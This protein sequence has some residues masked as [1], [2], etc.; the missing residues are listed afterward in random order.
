MFCFTCFVENLTFGLEMHQIGAIFNNNKMARNLLGER[1]RNIYEDHENDTTYTCSTYR[2]H[3]INNQAFI[4]MAHSCCYQLSL[5]CIVI[6]AKFIY[7]LNDLQKRHGELICV[8][9]TF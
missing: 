4:A 1:V 6:T 8:F 2:P 3:F 5:H 7:K 9:D